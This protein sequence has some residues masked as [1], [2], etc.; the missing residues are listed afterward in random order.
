METLLLN[1][2]EKENLYYEN[3]K[4]N[5]FEESVKKLIND[6]SVLKNELE[7]KSKENKKLKNII[8]QYKNNKSYRAVSNPRK[9][10]NINDEMLNIQKSANNIKKEIIIINE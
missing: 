6:I 10:T 4:M 1:Y 3:N 8:V 7:N 9:T 5:N 2:N